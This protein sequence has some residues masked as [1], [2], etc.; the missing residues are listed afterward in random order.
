VGGKVYVTDELSVDLN[1]A[2]FDFDVK[3]PPV[4]QV[5]EAQITDALLPNTP[6]HKVNIGFS[7]SNP[8]GF[9]AGLTARWVE[10]FS[11]AGGIFNGDVP[12]YTLV[13]LNAGY[14]LTKNVYLGVNVSNLLNRKHY[15]IFGGSVLER[16]GLATLTTTF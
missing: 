13:N 15:E 16:R 8:A 4:F 2:Y 12:E 10:K 3:S 6:R 11:W 5:K 7:Y 9:N 14:Q 1:W